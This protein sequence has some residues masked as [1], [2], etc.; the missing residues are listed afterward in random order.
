MPTIFI[1]FIL[2]TYTQ[3][4]WIKNCPDLLWRRCAWF[5]KQYF[6]ILTTSI[7]KLTWGHIFYSGIATT[8]HNSH[9]RNQLHKT[10]NGIWVFQYGKQKQIMPLAALNTRTECTKAGVEL[11]DVVDGYIRLSG[12]Q[13]PLS[14]YGMPVYW[15]YLRTT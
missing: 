14:T 5:S 9:Q 12:L 3:F 10:Q 13:H 11:N 8:S 2:S 1:P 4:T 15:I 6:C 7:M